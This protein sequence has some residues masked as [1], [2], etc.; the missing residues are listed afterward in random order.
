[1]FHCVLNQG[2]L[3]LT[4]LSVMKESDPLHFFLHNG[5]GYHLQRF[6]VKFKNPSP[7]YNN[8]CKLVTK[9]GHITYNAQIAMGNVPQQLLS[10]LNYFV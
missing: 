10:L 8:Y 3:S 9:V 5:S 1:M 4:S 2:C 7:S 6:N